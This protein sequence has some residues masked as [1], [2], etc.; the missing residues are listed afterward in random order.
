MSSIT[1]KAAIIEALRKPLKVGEI[2][3]PDLECGQV[4]VQVLR[5]GICGKQLVEINGVLGEDKYLPHLLGHEGGGIVVEIGPGVSQVKKGDHVVMHW[6]KGLGIEAR[7]PKYLCSD[8]TI[9]GGGFVTTFNEYSVVSEN[10]LTSIQDDI[11]LDIAAL[12]GCAVTTALGLINNE[13][14][15]KIGESIAVIG[16]GGVGLNVVQGAALVSANPIIAIDI[17]DYKLKLAQ[18]YGA[19]HVI[20][21]SNMDIDEEIKKIVGS[22]GVDVFVECTGL[23]E[24]ISKAYQ[25]TGVN[26]RTILVAQPKYDETLS[27][28]NMLRNFNGKNLITSQ[29]GQTAPHIDIQRYLNLYRSGK[30]SFDKLITHRYPLDEI[31]TAIENMKAGQVGRCILV[32]G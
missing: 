22:R 9:V 3:M 15:L 24:L 18:E 8:G 10:R 31:N 14:K 11:P 5:S 29:G 26:G 12:M 20:N 4:L 28:P 23:M 32:M 19:T 21:S 30:L 2:Q 25:M 6:R 7:P 1:A 13:A 16:C 27:I 17:F